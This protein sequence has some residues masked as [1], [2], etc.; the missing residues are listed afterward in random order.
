MNPLFKSSTRA[1]RSTRIDDYHVDTQIDVLPRASSADIQIG[2]TCN[3]HG[4]VLIRSREHL[5]EESEPSNSQGSSNPDWNRVHNPQLSSQRSVSRQEYESVII[6][7]QNQLLQQR[8]EMQVLIK[9]NEDLTGDPKEDSQNYMTYSWLTVHRVQYGDT[10][11]LFEDNPQWT[12]RGGQYH[13][14]GLHP[15]ARLR[16]FVDTR[17]EART[18]FLVL[19]SYDVSKLQDDESSDHGNNEVLEGLRNNTQVQFLSPLL[20][21]AFENLLEKNKTLKLNVDFGDSLELYNEMDS[22]EDEDPVMITNMDIVY[23][24]FCHLLER[25]PSDSRR[26][27]RQALQTLA[28][29]LKQE[30]GKKHRSIKR[31]LAGGSVSLMTLRY[32]FK[33]EDMVVFNKGKRLYGATLKSFSN[34]SDQEMSVCAETWA[35]DGKFYK[36]TIKQELRTPRQIYENS[37]VEITSLSCYPLS[38]AS[39]SVKDKLE[40]RGHT[41]WRCRRMAYVSYT[42]TNAKLDTDYV[43]IMLEYSLLEY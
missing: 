14:E 23:Y 16:K 39:G 33:R 9:V 27:E 1:S 25:A 21:V 34:Q 32:L 22:D 8:R 4:K 42:G 37:S 40:N 2:R 43:R 29:F 36:Q 10:E 12:W 26:E 41:F 11:R 7:L 5:S 13:L 18:V 31:S 24:H 38:F 17:R 35:F 30:F 28:D 6:E 3:Q 19:H 20:T 15:I